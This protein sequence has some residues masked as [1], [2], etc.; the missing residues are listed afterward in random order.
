M[1]V[2]PH[3]HG[4]SVAPLRGSMRVRVCALE[5]L[6][7]ISLTVIT[8]RGLLCAYSCMSAYR[9]AHTHVHAPH[10]ACMLIDL[11]AESYNPPKES[12]DEYEPCL[13]GF[14]NNSVTQAISLIETQSDIV[15]FSC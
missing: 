5:Q 10:V 2:P 1:D 3:N 12:A 15:V 7:S 4:V 6:G 13:R 8:R 9:H 14:Q 11:W